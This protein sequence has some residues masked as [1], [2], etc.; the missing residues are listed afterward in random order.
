MTVAREKGIV[1]A[2]FMNDPYLFEDVSSGDMLSIYFKGRKAI[3]FE[4]NV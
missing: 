4:E 1:Y 2:G 3:V